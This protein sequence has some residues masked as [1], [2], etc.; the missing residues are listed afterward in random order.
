M[1][2]RGTGWIPD[3]PDIND[4]TLEAN[5]IQNLANKY[6]SQIDTVSIENLAQMVKDALDTLRT[7]DNKIKDQ[8][9]QNIQEKLQANFLGEVSLITVKFHNVLKKGIDDPEVSLIKSYLES[10]KNSKWQLIETVLPANIK[11]K[12]NTQL[13]QSTFE[14]VKTILETLKYLKNKVD[15]FDIHHIRVLK[16]LAANVPF[17]FNRTKF[18]E[19]SEKWERTSDIILTE[20]IYLIDNRMYR[21]R[22]LIDMLFQFLESESNQSGDVT[23]IQERLKNPDIK[24]INY[25]LNSDQE[26]KQIIIFRN[27]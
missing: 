8:K 21:Q 6:Q 12:Y 16:E 9:I 14:M 15:G 19:L 7:P 26:K 27:L 23:K 10:I 20:Q 13:D 18:Q 22:M 11:L 2:K 24:V 3:Y 17:N 4:Y 1:L 25:Q 5:Q